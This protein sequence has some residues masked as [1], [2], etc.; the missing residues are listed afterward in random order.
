MKIF[1][2]SKKITKKHIWLYM[3]G[4]HFFSNFLQAT[5]TLLVPL[6]NEYIYAI[7]LVSPIG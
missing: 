5:I 2:T 4:S 7:C 1:I 6:K 3:Q